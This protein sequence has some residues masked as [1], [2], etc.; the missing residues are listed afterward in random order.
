MRVLKKISNLNIQGQDNEMSA[1]KI[2]ILTS[3][4][5]KIF[6]IMSKTLLINYKEKI[7]LF[8]RDINKEVFHMQRKR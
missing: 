5:K 6:Y 4:T 8:S 1:K 2:L 7:L 3:R